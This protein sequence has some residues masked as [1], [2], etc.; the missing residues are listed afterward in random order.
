MELP[1]SE[2]ILLMANSWWSVSYTVTAPGGASQLG[3]WLVQ[4]S[5][6]TAAKASAVSG[7]GSGAKIGAVSGPYS[8]KAQAQAGGI[9]I[10]G[11]SNAAGNPGGTASGSNPNN[12]NNANTTGGIQAE[13]SSLGSAACLAQFPQI[14]IPTPIVGTT[15]GPYCMFTK[16]E[17]RALIGGLLIAVGVIGGLVATV[18]MVAEGF[19]ST[20]IGKQAT[21]AASV[22]AVA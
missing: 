13:P 16:T 22:L 3:T 2:W 21:K 4:A 12:T 18:L 11:S 10:S 20:S 8:T 14:T 19:E 17:A 15:I 1:L 5:S 6:S 9:A 7:L